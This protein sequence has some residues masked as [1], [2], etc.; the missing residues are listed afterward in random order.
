MEDKETPL[1]DPFLTLEAGV[2]EHTL[3]LQTDDPKYFTNNLVKY[4]IRETLDDYF[5]LN[6]SQVTHWEPINLNILNC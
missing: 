5:I 2:G 3:S 1:T 4:Y 6:E